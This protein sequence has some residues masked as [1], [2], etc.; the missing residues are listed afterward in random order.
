TATV[1]RNQRQAIIISAIVTALAAAVG[2]I[3]AL[4]VASDITRPV[5]QLL[6]ATRE[7]E[8]GRLDQSIDVSTQ[9]EIGQ[10]S[11]TFNRMV[12]QLRRNERISETFG[13]YID[14]K[15]VEG[16]LERPEVAL[17]QGQRRTMTI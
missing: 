8:A 14:P 2:W 1:I 3:F 12:E 6:E 13:R 7:V 16:L 5:R 17:T 10:L 11:A 9:D 4:L 15:V